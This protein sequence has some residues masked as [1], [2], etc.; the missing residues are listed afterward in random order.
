MDV[1]VERFN[2]MKD[3]LTSCSTKSLQTLVMSG[4]STLRHPSL[5]DERTADC[6]KGRKL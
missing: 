2:R 6:F 4:V 3:L 1:A 5:Q